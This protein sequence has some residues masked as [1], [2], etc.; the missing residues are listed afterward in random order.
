KRPGAQAISIPADG[1]KVSEIERLVEE[2]KKTTDHVDILVANAGATWGAAFE[3]HSDKDWSKVMDLNVKG[4]FFLVQK[5]TPLLEKAATIEDPSRV[6]ITGSIAGMGL[7]SI[8]G[9][10]ATYSYSASKAAVIHL[11]KQFA[12]ALGPRH[13]LTNIIAPGF[14]PSKMSNGLLSLAGGAEFF[15]S[16]SPNLRLG[17]P[18]DFA[19]V[20]VF[21]ASRAGSHINGAV[22]TSDGGAL[23]KGRL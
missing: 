18:E 6:I 20:T 21:L 19:G 12:V 15:A 2:V 3:N 9:D 4:V 7:G 8:D 16:E 17:K 22:I 1:S 11:G 23:I 14:Y 13:I 5:F 10:N